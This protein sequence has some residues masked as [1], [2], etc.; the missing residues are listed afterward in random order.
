MGMTRV[1][2]IMG[3]LTGF[4]LGAIDSVR[5]D[6][7]AAETQIKAV[8]DGTWDR[9][10]QRLQVSPIVVVSDHALAGWTQGEMG[11][12]AL[13]RRKGHEWQIVLC[14]GDQLK[15]EEALTK[16]GLPADAAKILAARLAEAE[17]KIEPGRLALFSRFDGI[18]M[19]DASGHH[20]PQHAP[21]PSSQHK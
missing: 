1:I 2:A 18:V 8:M 5:A 10:D 15:S 16:I 20:P 9:P 19:M 6:D 4:V 14:S 13:L 3:L 17:G 21:H 7:L 11:G 12:R